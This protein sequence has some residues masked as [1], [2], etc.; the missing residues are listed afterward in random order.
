MRLVVQGVGQR[1]DAYF[2]RRWQD[3]ETPATRLVLIGQEL[4][5]GL[6]QQALQAAVAGV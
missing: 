1:F 3:G 6:L 5:A 4:D 2:D